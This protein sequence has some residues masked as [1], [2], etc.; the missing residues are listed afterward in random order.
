MSIARKAP[1]FLCGL[2]LGAFL[3]ASPSNLTAQE[4]LNRADLKAILYSLAN[5]AIDTE[6]NAES[7]VLLR[8][9]VSDLEIAMEKLAAGGE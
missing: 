2:A 7:I 4:T 8:D 1:A 9:R 5:L 6:V 3:T